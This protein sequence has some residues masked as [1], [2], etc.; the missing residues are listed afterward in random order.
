MNNV[1]IAR[2]YL[3]SKL[4]HPMV[5][6]GNGYQKKLITNYDYST[7]TQHNQYKNGEVLIF[8]KVK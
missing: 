8:L 5:F 2:E 1:N 6:L 4:Q 3:I 7:I